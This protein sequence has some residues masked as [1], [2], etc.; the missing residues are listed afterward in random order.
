AAIAG[1]KLPKLA[2]KG[3][4]VLVVGAGIELIKSVINM[5]G[6]KLSKAN[7][8]AEDRHDFVASI[9]TQFKMNLE[10]SEEQKILFQSIR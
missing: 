8:E 7:A 5:A 4:V 6:D 9:L 2:Q 1:K 10:E 3:A